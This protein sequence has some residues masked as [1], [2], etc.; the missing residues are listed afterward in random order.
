MQPMRAASAAAAE[1]GGAPG[2]ILIGGN[3]SAH[4]C[5]CSFT[6]GQGHC[7]PESGVGTVLYVPV[8]VTAFTR[9]CGP[10]DDWSKIR[11]ALQMVPSTILHFNKIPVC[12]Q[13]RIPE[14]KCSLRNGPKSP[15]LTARTDLQHVIVLKKHEIHELGFG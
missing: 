10:Q 5:V 3:V 2:K 4:W 14:L 15:I 8:P 7:V 11:P 9:A 12:M 1:L 13:N 6:R